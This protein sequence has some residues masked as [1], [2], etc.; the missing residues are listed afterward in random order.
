[1]EK[2]LAIYLFSTMQP[3]R[4]KEL[5]NSFALKP[6]ERKILID[7]FVTYRAK[8]GWQKQLAYDENVESNTISKRYNKALGKSSLFL[9]AYI[10]RVLNV[11]QK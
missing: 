7:C 8:R 10:S 6:E 4:V 11:P 5:I 9:V 2:K 1:M 3:E